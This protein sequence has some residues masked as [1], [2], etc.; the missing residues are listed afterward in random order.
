MAIGT[1]LIAPQKKRGLAAR[2]AAGTP[3]GQLDLGRFFEPVFD[4]IRQVFE[5]QP[6]S[7]VFI[8]RTEGESRIDAQIL[9]GDTQPGIQLGGPGR[10]VQLGLGTGEPLDLFSGFEPTDPSAFGTLGGTGDS[11]GGTGIGDVALG[12][13]VPLGVTILKK[14]FEKEGRSSLRSLYE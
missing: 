6:R 13:G 10:N 7:D 2:L 3:P 14:I 4:P 11:G 8:P 5:D 1:G 12:V 9:S